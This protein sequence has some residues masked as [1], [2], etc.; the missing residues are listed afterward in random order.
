MASDLEKLAREFK[1][2]E[3]SNFRRSLLAHA[4]IAR[5]LGAPEH[6]SS[7]YNFDPPA[8]NLPDPLF[9]KEGLL[10]YPLRAL[11]ASFHKSP[12][13]LHQL[14]NRGTVRAMKPGHEYFVSH[15]DVGNYIKNRNTKS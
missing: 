6:F 12:E 15:D 5:Q 13:W 11:A 4:N 9:T 7:E 14:V 8:D 1:G 2:E 3:F 10:V